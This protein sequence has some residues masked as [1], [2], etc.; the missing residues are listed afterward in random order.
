MLREV[1]AVLEKKKRENPLFVRGKVVVSTQDVRRH[2]SVIHRSY[3]IR[4]LCA[5][6]GESS[7]HAYYSMQTCTNISCE[8][9][10][11]RTGALTRICVYL[12]PTFYPNILH[13]SARVL[14]V[15][16]RGGAFGQSD[17]SSH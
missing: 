8:R 5:M 12:L 17:G 4:L 16:A 13:V 15:R 3:T 14:C 1:Q 2:G 9:A 10:C 6:P 7:L 11:V